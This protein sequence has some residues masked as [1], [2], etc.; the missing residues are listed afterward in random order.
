MATRSGEGVVCTR[1]G[2]SGIAFEVADTGASVLS[3]FALSRSLRESFFASAVAID[4]RM[5][6]PPIVASEMIV[7][8]MS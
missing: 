3:R 5:K 8:A 2:G 6:R 4:P 7:L 1:T